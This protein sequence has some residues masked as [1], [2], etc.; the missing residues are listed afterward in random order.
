MKH[1]Y[2]T[3]FAIAAG[4]VTASAAWDGTSAPWTNGDGTAENPYLIENE[5][6]LAALG[7]SVLAGETY[8][9]KHF[10]LTSDLDFDGRN[11]A[12]IGLYD[13]YTIEGE[14]FSESKPFLGVFDGGFHTIDKMRIIMDHEDEYE[15]G[16]VGL[17]AMGRA[18]TQVRNLRMGEDVF[19]DGNGSPDVGA[20]MGIAY[21]STIENCSFAGFVM[22]GSTESGGIL[23]RGEADTT[24]KGCVNTGSITGN[25]FT[26]GIAGSVVGTAISDCV[27]LGNINGNQGYWVAGLVGWELTSTL[28]RCVSAGRVAG[29]TGSSYLPGISPVCAELERST[30]TACYYAETL[31]GCTPLS[32]QTGV[33][34][35]S[36]EELKG[37]DVLEALNDG[38]DW[39]LDEALACPVPAWYVGVF[40]GID[41]VSD[42]IDGEI[43]V[44]TGSVIIRGGGEFT[45]CDLFGRIVASGTA[46][47]E[48]IVPCTE[49]VYVVTVRAGSAVKSV[50]VMI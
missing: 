38:G 31:T 48:C 46:D 45:V 27:N 40:N 36:E 6:H 42:A 20:I 25:S 24:V 9:G 41:N 15:L 50:K 11:F 21:G 14:A 8:E 32:A 43:L 22:K 16:G 33:Y 12:P 2:L 10:L 29:I 37:A 13:E 17:F 1:I 35:V 26:G 34:G 49:G 18:S 5:Q 3:L 28:D 7:E 30:A 39:V 47:A 19:V 4:A 23:G 44:G